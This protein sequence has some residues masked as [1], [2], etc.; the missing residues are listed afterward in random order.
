[1]SDILRSKCSHRFCA[2]PTGGLRVKWVLIHPSDVVSPV[3]LMA[4]LG[5]S[6]MSWKRLLHVHEQNCYRCLLDSTTNCPTDIVFVVDES[7]SVGSSNFARAKSFLSQI[8]RRLDINSGRTRV[9]LVTYSTSVRRR[10]YLNTYSSVA[11]V[12]RAISRLTYPGGSTDTAAAISYVRRW[13]LT[14]YR[15]DRRSA[16]NV[17]VVLTDGKSKSTSATQVCSVQ[18]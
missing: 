8:V 3:G 18:C 10:F 16:D 7:G 13:M 6:I 15:G 1:M 14:S 9:G 5:C 2:N 4:L 11:S 17:V 12:R